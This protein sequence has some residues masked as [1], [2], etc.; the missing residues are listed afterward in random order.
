ME[1]RLKGNGEKAGAQ[2]AILNGPV[3]EAV[4]EKLA[5]KGLSLRR[6]LAVKRI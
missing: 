3:G 2:F 4:T 5:E 1:L 6:I